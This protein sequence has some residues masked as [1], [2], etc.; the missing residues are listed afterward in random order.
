M[1]CTRETRVSSFAAPSSASEWPTSALQSPSRL[2]EDEARAHH[3]L[4]LAGARPVARTT[5]RNSSSDAAAAA[6][7]AAAA[8]PAAAAAA[9]CACAIIAET[10]SFIICS[11]ACQPSRVR[12]SISSR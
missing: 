10:I 1:N 6:A 8:A 7:G 11:T 2:A 4:Q 9:P 12:R 3:P 5:K